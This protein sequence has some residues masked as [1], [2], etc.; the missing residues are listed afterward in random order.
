MR[1]LTLLALCIAALACPG[2]GWLRRKKADG[3]PEPLKPSERGALG[4]PK[5]LEERFRQETLD[6][7]DADTA[8]TRKGLRLVARSLKDEYAPDEP[9]IINV[10]LQNRTG[11][12]KAPKDEPRD[13]SV[14][15]E[16]FVRVGK[17]RGGKARSAEWLFKFHIRAEK[18]PRVVYRSPRF[19]VPAAERANYYHYVILPKQAYVGRRF[20]F[21]PART[22]DWLAPG[23]Y[24][25]LIS[26]EVDDKFP[27]VIRNRH[28]TQEQVQ[29]L[30]TDLAYT[31]IWTG[32]VQ[33]NRVTFTIRGKRRSWLPF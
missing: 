12:T 25:I 18:G 10:Q 4:L 24:S 3:K 33:S 22:R 26:Y 11:A 1:T 13:L 2:C 31:R 14:Y 20:T 19:E 28:F 6:D 30:G 16:P 9:I 5:P 23:T 29:I 27:L 17:T 8:R 7:L 32:K 15:F 21:P